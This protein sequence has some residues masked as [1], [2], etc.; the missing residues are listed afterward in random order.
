MEVAAPDASTD[1]TVSHPDTG[2]RAPE[3]SQGAA[4]WQGPR[5][6]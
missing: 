6:S 2:P 4:P 5:E 1:R 3:K